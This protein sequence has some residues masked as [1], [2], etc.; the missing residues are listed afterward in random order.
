[1]PNFESRIET[2]ASE[3][4]RDGRIGMP[5]GNTEP[6]QTDNSRETGAASGRRKLHA[7]F[8]GDGRHLALDRFDDH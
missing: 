8:D 5:R 4:L 6:Q 7:V 3:W 1:M 2:S